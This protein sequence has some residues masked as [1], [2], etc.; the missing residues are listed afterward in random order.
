MPLTN[1]QFEQTKLTLREAY[2]KGMIETALT[3]ALNAEQAYPHERDTVLYW[4]A[5]LYSLL[6]NKQEAIQALQRALQEGVWWSKKILESESDFDHIRNEPEY[7][8]IA[9]AMEEIYTRACNAA[10]PICIRD[11]H[12][13][14]MQ[15]VL[16]LHWRNDNVEHYRRYFPQSQNVAMIYVQS[17]QVASSK[18]YCWDNKEK[19]I[20]DI[21][22]VLG[23]ELEDITVFAGTSQGAVIA[24]RLALQYKKNYV[25]IMP[26]L[27]DSS[28]ENEIA[29]KKS[30]YRFLAGERDGF[31]P[32][33]KETNEKLKEKNIDSELISMGD[34]GHYFPEDF[35]RYYQVVIDDLFA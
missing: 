25:G 4:K 27:K 6:D 8:M 2:S 20:N 16:N 31:Y 22:S 1:T 26:A 11:K 35:E 3:I 12:K 14:G 34:V 24:L 9:D 19:A 5:C 33:C 17:S 30:K 7:R 13:E 10:K 23:S 28:I 21:A 29:D 32:V 18:G 15:K